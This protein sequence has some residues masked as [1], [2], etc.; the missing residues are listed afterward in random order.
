MNERQV[1]ALRPYLDIVHRHRLTSVCT[2]L[3]GLSITACL[4]IMLPDIFQSTTLILV[5]P[6]QVAQGYLATPPTN[7]TLNRVKILST[8]ALSRRNLSEVITTFGVY[9]RERA[10]HEPMDELVEYMRKRI[11][12]DLPTQNDQRKSDRLNSFTLS[13]EYPNAV[14]AQKVTARLADIFINED[15][16]E[17]AEQ[18]NAA[19]SF[20]HDQV[21]TAAHQLQQKGDQIRDYKLHNNGSLPEDL[22]ANLA[23][24]QQLQAQL[25]SAEQALQSINLESPETQL[26]EAKAKLLALKSRYGSAYPDVIAAQRQVRLLESAK[27]TG[28]QPAARPIHTAQQTPL[29]HRVQQL[30]KV[31]DAYNSRIAITPAHEQALDSLN[32]DYAVL[33]KNYQDLLDKELD[34]GVEAQL[35]IRQEGERFRVL[36]PANLP[37][38]PVRPN[39]IAIAAL[40]AVL[41]LLAAVAL[42]FAAYFTDTSFHDSD[43]L[44]RQY[45]IPILASIPKSEG[46]EGRSVRRLLVF[47]A[48]AASSVTVAM[49]S[50]AI[51][52]YATMIF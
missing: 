28:D 36:D 33:Q 38:T 20:L 27:I 5:Q 51:W 41:S 34:S 3:V 32:R 35:Q 8:E 22:N 24:L 15:L 6:Q 42:P 43:E 2:L 4:L 14:L 7:D 9:P 30:Q 39:R 40:G 37:L 16:R 19:T 50:V 31:I 13:F 47:R 49:A 10:Q 46:P 17:R 25:A 29:E 26:A 23:E 18:A 44:A 48:I 11:S 12:I 1:F 21:A 45:A 52:L